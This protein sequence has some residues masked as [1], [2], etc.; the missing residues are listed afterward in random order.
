MNFLIFL[1]LEFS[2]I[3]CIIS[4]QNKVCDFTEHS[5]LPYSGFKLHR[6]YEVRCSAPPVLHYLSLSHCDQGSLE[7]E[8]IT[9]TG[10]ETD[11]DWNQPACLVIPKEM[12][13]R[14]DNKQKRR[15]RGFFNINKGRKFIK[16]KLANLPMI[17][18]ISKLPH[19]VKISLGKRSK[20]YG[21]GQNWIKFLAQLSGRL[22]YAE[23]YSPDVLNTSVDELT[24]INYN[25]LNDDDSSN[26]VCYKFA[27]RKRYA[28]R[29]T[30]LFAPLTW[31]GG[32]FQ[33]D[34]SDEDKLRFLNHLKDNNN[35]PFSIK[36]EESNTFPVGPLIAERF[37]RQWRIR[38]GL[39]KSTLRV[40]YLYTPGF[41]D[42][43]FGTS[44]E[45]LGLKKSSLIYKDHISKTSTDDLN[46]NKW[47]EEIN[48][49]ENYN[50]TKN[51]IDLISRTTKKTVSLIEEF[52]ENVSSNLFNDWDLGIEINN[53]NSSI[54]FLEQKL[55]HLFSKYKHPET[56]L[57]FTKKFQKNWDELR[58]SK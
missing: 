26:V 11:I 39:S 4:S 56:V 6:N 33:C 47:W 30:T 35:L 29:D 24:P 51:D 1:F 32:I 36:C 19:S 25:E 48:V 55:F 49:N 20:S 15:D 37:D 50:Y 38:E 10:R 23:Y 46:Y 3:N 40:P 42:F 7:Y 9:R 2:L 21:C 18:N 31:V 44:G 41:L 5:I 57:E 13:K 43:R 28:I 12:R 58:L 27:R 52:I 14:L 17:D 22:G 54:T 45:V 34:I 53:N 16:D 8:R